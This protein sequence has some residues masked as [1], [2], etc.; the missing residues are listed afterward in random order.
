MS[1]FPVP[2][3]IDIDEIL[4]NY[5]GI[6]DKVEEELWKRGIGET[7]HAPSC[8]RDLDA[9]IEYNSL[10]DGSH[11]E[12][13]M[14]EDLTILSDAATGQYFSLFTHW[15]NYLQ[16]ETTREK[17]RLDVLTQTQ[18][19]LSAALRVWYKEE[20]GLSANLSDDKVITDD[21]WLEVN[22]LVTK[23]S[24]L[25]KELNCR[26][27]QMKR[28]LNNISREQTRRAEEVERSRHSPDGRDPSWNRGSKKSRFRTRGR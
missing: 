20:V 28:I 2:K 26:Y 6:A 24:L 15:A 13:L 14:P 10:P 9:L 5:G 17:G 8:P 3:S 25:Y 19:V 22:H 18:K 27:E 16:S 7:L 1:R 4:E 12:P 21:R 11:G 23:S